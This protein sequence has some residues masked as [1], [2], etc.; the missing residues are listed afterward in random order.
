[1]QNKLAT[2]G[3]NLKHM[4]ISYKGNVFIKFFK[5]LQNNIDTKTKMILSAAVLHSTG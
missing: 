3:V 2:S 1:M 4:I 5:N